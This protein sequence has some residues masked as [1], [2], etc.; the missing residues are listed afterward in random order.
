MMKSFHLDILRTLYV[1]TPQQLLN[2]YHKVNKAGQYW[3]ILI[4]MF[5]SQSLESFADITYNSSNPDQLSA[6]HN[7]QSD[8]ELTMWNNY[9]QSTF[10][11][12]EDDANVS[13]SFCGIFVW[14][15]WCW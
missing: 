12:E 11:V 7:G 6:S 13:S 1:T 4:C 5:Q 3:Q 8:T 2:G 15:K 9:D 10:D 14:I